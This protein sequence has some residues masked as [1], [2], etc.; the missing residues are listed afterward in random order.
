MNPIQRFLNRARE[1]I[2]RHRDLAIF[3]AVGLLVLLLLAGADYG[4]NALARRLVEHARA[5]YRERQAPARLTALPQK[6]ALPPREQAL[7][8]EKRSGGPAPSAVPLDVAKAHE[9]PPEAP[10]PPIQISRPRTEKEKNTLG[11]LDAAPP[12]RQAP[13]PT[14][15]VNQHALVDSFGESSPVVTRI[16]KKRYLFRNLSDSAVETSAGGKEEG[17]ERSK[18]NLDTFAPRGEIIEAAATMSAFSSN[19]DIDV[20][21]AVW[22]PFYFQGNLLLE[23]GDRL[24]GTAKG[25]SAFRDR[26]PVK[27]DRIVLKDGRTLPID[28]V[29]LHTDGTEGI[30]GYRV[31]ELGKQMVGPL[32]GALTQG[33]LYS[34][35]MQASLFTMNPY[36]GM[37]YSP[38]GMFGA[39]PYGGMMPNTGINGSQMMQ[40]G[41]MMGGMMGGSQAVNQLMQILSQDVG[42]Y[43]PYTFVPAGTRFRVYLKNYLDVSQA[44]Y[45]K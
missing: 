25:N 30:K 34:L 26:M 39:Y 2:R 29:A 8:V 40:Q 23:P 14:G 38:Y 31:S 7:V 6:R 24:L 41:L 45:G 42:Q 37:G 3:S 43:K 13:V 4:V 22:L 12:N 20:V 1:W 16:A 5:I 15:L 17:D 10:S 11:P 19:T 36:M 44:D 9:R 33:A 18:I 35:M 21:G 28:G 32:L 27:F